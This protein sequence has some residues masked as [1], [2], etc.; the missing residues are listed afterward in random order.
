M[1]ITGL[2]VG[3]GGGAVEESNDNALVIPFSVQLDADTIGI[4]GLVTDNITNNTGNNNEHVSAV[5][6]QG[7]D[8]EKIHEHTAAGGGVGGGVTVSMWK[9]KTAVN[10]T[11]SDTITVTLSANAVAKAARVYR[12]GV[13]AGNDLELEDVAESA[14]AGNGWGALSISGLPN[15]EH[16]FIRFMGK[17]SATNTDLTP[18]AN[19]TTTGGNRSSSNGSTAVIVRGEFRITTGTNETSNPT[20]TIS[21]DNV[22]VMAAF[23]EVAPAAGGQSPRTMHQQR[24]RRAA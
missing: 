10:L 7:Q 4:F 19:W 16:L 15:Q 18:T 14:T 2:G 1:A 5:D 12:F 17:E 24:L 9:R 22:S 8:W 6:S 23:K 11:L 21:S 13:G 20:L 3:S